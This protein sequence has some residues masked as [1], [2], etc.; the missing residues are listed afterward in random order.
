MSG[1]AGFQSRHVN[2]SGRKT[3]RSNLLGTNCPPNEVVQI[4]G[5]KNIMSLNSYNSVSIDKQV[6][7]STI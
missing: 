1:K 2:H 7:M 5:H 4:S 6:R 3:C